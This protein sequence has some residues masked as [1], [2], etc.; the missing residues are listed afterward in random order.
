MPSHLW[1]DQDAAARPELDGL[2]YRS[3]ILG[4]DRAVVNIYGGNTSLS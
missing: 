1:N 4:C 2:V 3:T